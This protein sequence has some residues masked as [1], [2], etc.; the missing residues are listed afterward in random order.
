V[1]AAACSDLTA[2][3]GSPEAVEGVEA[4]DLASWMLLPAAGTCQ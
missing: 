2:V 3:Q 4:A 1:Y